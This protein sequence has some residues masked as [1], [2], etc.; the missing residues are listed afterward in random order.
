[1]TIKDLTLKIA[2]DNAIA[3]ES[4]YRDTKEIH[5]QAGSSKGEDLTLN[6]L[7]G[8]DGGS[9][10]ECYRCGNRKHMADTCPLKTKECFA[11]SRTGHTSR[12][13]RSAKKGKASEEDKVKSC[14]FAEVEGTDCKQPTEAAEIDGLNFSSLSCYPLIERTEHNP[15]VVH[16]SLNGNDVPM[17]LDT[18]AAVSV[19]SSSCYDRVSNSKLESSPLRLKTYT[20]EI[21]KPLGVGMVDVW[22]PAMQIAVTVV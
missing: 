12:M 3:I 17:E 16:V 6:H 8:R 9:R 2:V 19:M 1:M 14:N 5:A 20:G 21:V 15:V 7:S 11:C 18:G 22:R 13:C 10:Q 4:A